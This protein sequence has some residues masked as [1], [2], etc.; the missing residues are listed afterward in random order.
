MD[1]EVILEILEAIKSD[2]IE[3]FSRN[4]E[5]KKSYLS[6]CFGRFPMLSICYLYNSS[7]ILKEYE[8]ALSS[9][10]IYTFTEE[11]FDVYKKFRVYAKRCLR[12]YVLEK[13]IV[14]PLEMLAVMEESSYLCEVYPN[15]AKTQKIND[16]IS[17]IYRINHNQIIEHSED[18]II[19]KNKRL[20]RL[21]KLIVITAI[22]MAGVMTLLSAGVWATFDFV[23]GN[24]K[25]DNPYK[26]TNTKQF[27]TAM[28]K[29][30]Q[31]F[32]LT[33]DIT[34]PASWSAKD[35]SGVLDG[36]GHTIYIKDSTAK[37]FV[38]TLTGKLQNINF[39]LG[40]MD[41][42]LSKS[43][44]LIVTT[45]NGNINNLSIKLNAKLNDVAEEDDV[46][47][48]IIAY[49]NNGE[50]NGCSVDSVVEFMSNGVSNT[51]F[52]AIAAKNNGSV[53]ECQTSAQSKF[54]TDNVDVSGLVIENGENGTVKN[55]VNNAEIKQQSSNSSWLPNVSGVV[56]LNSG[57]VSNCTNNAKITGI[58]Q[59]SDNRLDVYVGGIVCIN[60]NKIIK[61]KNNADIVGTAVN[62]YVYAGGIVSYNNGYSSY[63]Q[64]SCSYGQIS[65]ES[66][67]SEQIFVFA[68]GIAGYN[69]GTIKDSYS[70]ATLISQTTNRFLGGV[71]GVS[72]YL[73]STITNNY[74]VTRENIKYGVATELAQGM[75]YQ[76]VDTGVTVQENLE[77]LKGKEVY[78][79]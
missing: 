41:T 49:E 57:E 9:I 66:A 18:K 27:E 73:S 72:D 21:Q 19:I 61:C 69:S 28:K 23:L 33:K 68:G 59:A 7:K 64:N 67:N 25:S 5:Q 47:A 29:G 40:D 54:Y 43:I 74:Y 42:E 48:A 75:L 63:I 24:G 10:N 79:A 22:I 70:V 60:N 30:G 37:G 50:I 32:V 6:I 77:Q 11:D 15:S 4:I 36:D 52:A 44:G 13:N 55:C 51:Y 65:V 26:V 34:L 58:S 31:S 2:D 8:K 16:N 76:G 38:N 35:F 20:S 39:A 17:K 45:N 53:S 3:S 14:S 12:L 62:Y 1:R 78:W 46:Y 56:L 71:I